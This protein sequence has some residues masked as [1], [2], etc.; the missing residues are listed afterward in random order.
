MNNGGRDM[1]L[2]A[3]REGIVALWADVAAREWRSRVVGSGLPQ[4]GGNPYWGSG[5]VDVARV[6]ND[7]V[8][9]VVTCEVSIFLFLSYNVM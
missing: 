4:S 6:G 1:V 7:A 3:S 9:Y 2:I 8:G 5:S